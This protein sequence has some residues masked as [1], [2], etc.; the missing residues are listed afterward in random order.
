VGLAGGEFGELRGEHD[1]ALED[2]H[3]AW[4]WLGGQV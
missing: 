1:E 3:V 4:G 2:F